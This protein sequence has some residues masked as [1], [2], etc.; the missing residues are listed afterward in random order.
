[1]CGFIGIVD[2]EGVHVDRL[3]T[4]RDVIAHRGPDDAGLFVSTDNKVGLAFR[5]LSIIDL[6]E[7]GHQPMSN[8]DGT[9]WIV[10]NGEIYNF[11]ELRTELELTGYHFSS[12]TD[13]ET[14]LHGYEE[15]GIKV[16]EKLRG[17]FAFAIWDGGLERVFLARDRLGIKP[18]FYYQDGRRFIFASEIKAILAMPGVQREV[19]FRGI[20]DYLTYRYIPTP[21][22]AYSG[23]FK[24]A[25][26][27]FA[28]FDK[29]H[30]KVQRYWEF[31]LSV[32]LDQLSER[33][34]VELVDERLK[35]SV[36]SHL[37]SDVP[38]GVFLSGGM[39]SSTLAIYMSEIQA[40]P[41]H[42]FSIGFDVRE[43]SE[44]PY[45]K[46]IA[47][48]VHSQHHERILTWP[49]IQGQLKLVVQ[50][51]DEPFAD[52]SSIP[53]I[54]VSR[55]ARE[56]VK[57]V[58]S[59]EGGDEAFGGYTWY[60]QM[61][62][63]NRAREFMP[64]WLLA[65]LATIGRAWP[66]GRLRG[67]Y[68]NRLTFLSRAPLDQYARLMEWISPEEK[69]QL[70]PRE[71]LQELGEYDDGWYLRQFWQQTSDPITRL[72]YLDLNTYLPDQLLV[73]ADR[74]S[75]AVSL[76]ARVPF[77]DHV[78]LETLIAIPGKMR[79]KD[80]RTKYLQRR[81]ME[82]RLPKSVL[83]RPKMGFVPPIKQWLPMVQL[84]WIRAYLQHGAAVAM[85]LIRPDA[86]DALTEVQWAAKVWILL[87][88]E[89]WAR[90]ESGNYNSN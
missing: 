46:F 10:F 5:R 72:Q 3:K 9:I 57:V 1:M 23:I 43:S 62:D 79:V 60:K 40:D 55:L 56:H 29:T 25:P 16:V 31:D 49:Q 28:C 81:V 67:N 63:L 44:L 52:T 74:A 75:M 18:L 19:N 20:Y 85:G 41:F 77:L 34:V 65:G 35:D 51:Y 73:K 59:G 22:T 70:V 48:Q 66:S 36:D 45:A 13:T 17:M 80:G 61:Y 2:C 50:V 27:H 78:L 47:N 32:Q 7:S 42:T 30:L 82:G 39:D 38:V 21:Y 8:K 64:G 89:T 26:G 12:R 76:E 71:R 6:T 15:W 88:L 14:I 86:L 69:R 54:E 11:A 58:L 84:P 37:V 53:T 68:A 87:V 4:A 33:E 83:T 24:L 90:N